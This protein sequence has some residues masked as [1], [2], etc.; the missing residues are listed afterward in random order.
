MSTQ[1]TLPSSQPRIP[2]TPWTLETEGLER[3]L[4]ECVRANGAWHGVRCTAETVD[5]FM[6]NRFV[7]TVVVASGLLAVSAYW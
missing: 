7:S 5:A 2:G 6:N 3:H 1:S 4:N